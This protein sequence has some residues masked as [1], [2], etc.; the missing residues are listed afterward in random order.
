MRVR[1]FVV[2]AGLAGLMGAAP[3]AAAQPVVRSA[4][5]ER[6]ALEAGQQV[7][8]TLTGEAL[9]TIE[10]VQVLLSGR[11]VASPSGALVPTRDPRSRDLT[12]TADK[13]A[14]AGDYTVQVV[15]ARTRRVARTPISLTVKRPPAPA[16]AP[17]FTPVTLDTDPLVMTGLRFTPIEI[18]TNPL[19]MT[20]LRFTPLV[21]DTNPLV[22]TG[23]RFTPVVLDTQ[24]LRMTGLR[25]EEV[26]R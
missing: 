2:L 1:P 14:A 11:P 19:V 21:I 26:P 7:R 24:T 17:S 22:M 4:S 5:P 6:V 3:P 13:A 8:I 16:P 9:D 20:G 18:D 10:S 23:L 25:E 15:E 12:I